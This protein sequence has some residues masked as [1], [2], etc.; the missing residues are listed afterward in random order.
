MKAIYK[1]ENILNG[2][3][4]IGSSSNVDKRWIR[5]QKDLKGGRHHN[6]YLQRSFNKYGEE[7]FEYSIL[8]TLKED[9]NISFQFEREAYYITT[10]EPEY[11]IGG[12]C[13]GDNFTKHPDRERLREVHRKNLQKLREAGKI[14]VTASGEDN[15][16]WKGAVHTTCKCGNK[17]S[18]GKIQCFECHNVSG[19]NNPFWGKTHSE[20]TK[21]KISEA[22]KGI[23]NLRDSKAIVADFKEY[24]SLSYA[25]DCLGVSIGTI[26]YRLRKCWDGYYYL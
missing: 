19:E 14:P 10:L 24:R 20:E 13:G 16:N 9:C 25:A 23:P 1:I 7:C 26:H 21:M 2:K 11:N 22:N 17:K 5:H 15:P 12:V 8:E 6:T 3:I 18:H 4:Y